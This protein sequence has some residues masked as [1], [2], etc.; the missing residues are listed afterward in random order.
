MAVNRL[1]YAAQTPDTT[2]FDSPS[3]IPLSQ[4]DTGAANDS[5]VQLNDN[6]DPER[7]WRKL[8]SMCESTYESSIGLSL[9]VIAGAFMS[10][11]STLVKML[12]S[13]DPPVLMLEVGFR[14]RYDDIH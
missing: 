7:G 2:V 13:I 3:A 8:S 11:M 12:N 9:I 10:L 1:P 5:V 14:C 4:L 6:P